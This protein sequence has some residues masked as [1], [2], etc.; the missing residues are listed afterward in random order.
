MDINA[1]TT[2]SPRAHYPAGRSAAGVAGG[3]N[4]RDLVA[5]ATAGQ[6]RARAADPREFIPDYGNGAPATQRTMSEAEAKIT[7]A[8]IAAQA[9]VYAPLKRDPVIATVPAAEPAAPPV[10]SGA[11]CRST[12]RPWPSKAKRSHRAR[13]SRSRWT[14]YVPAINSRPAPAMRVTRPPSPRRGVPK[15]PTARLPPPE[16]KRRRPAHAA[17]VRSSGPQHGQIQRHE[18]QPSGSLDRCVF[19]WCRA[20]LQA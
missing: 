15:K 9:N 14:R 19:R 7:A 2:A 12:A 8:Q 11:F 1:L 4:F 5:S 3:D 16:P 13:S 10:A 18:I 6:P 17:M 20:K